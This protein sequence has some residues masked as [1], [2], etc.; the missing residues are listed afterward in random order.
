[1]TFSL[2]FYKTWKL[3]DPKITEPNSFQHWRY[4]IQ[5]TRDQIKAAQLS[6][7]WTLIGIYAYTKS[8]KCGFVEG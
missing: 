4:D 6:R 5:N 7:D 2:S 8:L 1:M 3:I